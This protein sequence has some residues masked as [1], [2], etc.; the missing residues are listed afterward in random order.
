MNTVLIRRLA[1]QHRQKIVDKY[2]NLI[3][4]PKPVTPAKAGVQN[5]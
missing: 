2:D 1:H 5:P 4:S 3:K